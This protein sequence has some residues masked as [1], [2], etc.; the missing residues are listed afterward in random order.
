MRGSCSAAAGSALRHGL[1][2][3]GYTYADA[4]GVEEGVAEGKCCG[5]GDVAM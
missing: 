5:E 2:G 1:M 4:E 3:E